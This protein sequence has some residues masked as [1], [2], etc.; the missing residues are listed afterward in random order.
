MKASQKVNFCWETFEKQGK[1]LR[2]K[3]SKMI[4]TTTEN[5]LFLF[6]L[7]KS[8]KRVYIPDKTVNKN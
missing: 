1:P 7:I 2:N 5:I 8:R 3:S 6:L 4:L